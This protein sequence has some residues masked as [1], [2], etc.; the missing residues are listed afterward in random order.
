MTATLHYILSGALTPLSGVRVT[1]KPPDQIEHD[2]IQKGLNL[3]LYNVVK[4]AGFQ[5]LDSPTYNSEGELV[6]T[7][8]L[9]LNLFYLLTAYTKD[10]ND[11]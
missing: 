6:K 8:A 4:N 11:L 3:F 9:T 2:G 10:S 5:N 1:A 7:P